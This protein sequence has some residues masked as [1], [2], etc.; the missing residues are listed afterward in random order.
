MVPS[1][2]TMDN[3]KLGRIGPNELSWAK[4]YAN[5]HSCLVSNTSGHYSHFALAVL[6]EQVE[7]ME[8]VIGLDTD[9]QYTGKAMGTSQV[10]QDDRG[11]QE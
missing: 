4:N 3:I 11:V 6:I 9:P 5:E 8:S 7:I 10:V 1:K 2:E